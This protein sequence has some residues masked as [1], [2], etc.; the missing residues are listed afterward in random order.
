MEELCHFDLHGVLKIPRM[1][2]I[3]HRMGRGNQI[4][5]KIEMMDVSFGFTSKTLGDDI[6]SLFTWKLAFG[7]LKCHLP[8]LDTMRE[9][10]F[11]WVSWFWKR[12]DVV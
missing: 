8:N 7:G 3:P 9:A 1:D 6:I 4:H 10:R 2:V 5:C 12:D 11:F